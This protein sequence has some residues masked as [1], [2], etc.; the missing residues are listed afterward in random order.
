MEE[1]GSAFKLLVKE[2]PSDALLM[3]NARKRLSMD[4]ERADCYQKMLHYLFDRSQKER[5][6]SAASCSYIHCSGNCQGGERAS[7][8][9]LCQGID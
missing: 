8:S 7:Q 6:A 9:G 4:N 1:P 5:E 2:P 3:H